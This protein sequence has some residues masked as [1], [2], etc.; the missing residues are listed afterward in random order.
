MMM[1]WFLPNIQSMTLCYIAVCPLQE[2]HYK[3]G[4]HK[5]QKS[6]AVYKIAIHK[7]QKSKSSLQKPINDILFLE[8]ASSSPSSFWNPDN[9]EKHKLFTPKKPE[10]EQKGALDI[11]SEYI[12]FLHMV[13]VCVS[14]HRIWAAT[15][16][17]QWNYPN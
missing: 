9:Q 3:T 16:S 13:C 12:L 1:G 7:Q 5:Q 17:S 8:S 10:H 14:L 4:I 2:L 11:Q 15:L 6:K